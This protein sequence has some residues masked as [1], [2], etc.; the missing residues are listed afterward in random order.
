MTLGK[1]LL[2]IVKKFGFVL[3]NKFRIDPNQMN[4]V[5]KRK[6]LPCFNPK[7][8]IAFSYFLESSKF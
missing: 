6:N 4:S 3:S 7:A 1:Q 2:V 8:E 5:F